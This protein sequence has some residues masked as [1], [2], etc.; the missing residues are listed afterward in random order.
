[1]TTPTK[2]KMLKTYL[3]SA[4]VERPSGLRTCTFGAFRCQF[5]I[6]LSPSYD[7]TLVTEGIK[8]PLT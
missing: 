6:M 2:N 4:S 3:E 8:K 7:A 5:G 1:M